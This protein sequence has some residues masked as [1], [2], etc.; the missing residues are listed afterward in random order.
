SSMGRLFDALSALA[1]VRDAVDYEGQAAIEFEA[2]ADHKVTQYYEFKIDETGIIHAETVIRQAVIDLHEG[3]PPSDVSAKFHTGVARLITAVACNVRE[4]RHL[5]RV[6][7]SG[8][9]FQN[10]FLHDRVCAM[11]RVEGFEVFTH[12]RVPANDGGISLG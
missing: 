11:L 2:I 9:V 3:C 4:Q 8:G 7:L 6:A 10:M 12:S 5:N 1:G